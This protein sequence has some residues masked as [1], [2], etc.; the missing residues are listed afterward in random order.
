MSKEIIRT[1]E[2][3]IASEM[4]TLGNVFT[5]VRL[6]SADEV[7]ARTANCEN[8]RLED[9][10]YKV[11][12]RRRPCSNCI[13][14]RAL[15]EKRQFAKIVRAGGGT[16]YVVADY[17]EVD[18]KPCVME[19]IGKFDEDIMIDY[20]DENKSNEPAAEYFEKSYTDVLTGTYNRRYYEEYES[21]ETITGGI[22]MI[23]VDDFK[24]YNDV[25][26]HDMGDEVLKAIANVIKSSVRS[27]D[28]VVRYG[29]DEFLLIVSGVK[30]EAFARCLRDIGEGVR[31]ITFD[32]Y[33]AIKPS[34]STGFVIC[35]G[36][37]VKN[38][39]SR[40]DEFMYLAKKK[41]DFVVTDADDVRETALRKKARVL[42]VDDSAFNREIISSILKNE[43]E[44]IEAENGR[45]ALDKMN[46]YGTDVSAVL[47]DLIMPEMD[48]FE[49]LDNM[50][51]RGALTDIPVI[52]ITGDESNDSKRA[53]YEKG[54]ADYIMRPFDAKVVYR[55][56]TNAVKLY[57]RQKRLISRLTGEIRDKEKNRNMI[58]EILSQIV[59]SADV[60]N[61]TH[62][63]HIMK[64]TE[65]MLRK[66]AA[67]GNYGITDRDVY[68]ISTAAALHDIGKSRIDQSILNKKT[69][70]TPEEVEIMK[71][72]TVWGEKM[73][74]KIEA[75]A[76][77]PLVKYACEICRHHHERYDGKGYPDGL[78]G[79]E[80]PVSAQAVSIC[81]V[82]DALVTERSYKPAYSHEKAMAMIKNGE[83]GKF[84]P[85]LLECLDEC[86]DEFASIIDEGGQDII[87]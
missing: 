9:D 80:I 15:T 85:L 71:T 78:A 5:A 64:F 84:N 26:G 68:V 73:L 55:R 7:G 79:D 13:S 30:K 74:K 69:K 18:G 28:T 37:T 20:A 1:T 42:V 39:V 82:Y 51:A 60:D 83:C 44:I 50:N 16:F 58:V 46:E 32:D 27:G 17:R 86:A 38:A 52:A 33:P 43:Y 3:R 35:S 57:S 65:L 24:I 22:A 14:Y 76:N 34:V 59:E 62:A 87:G 21:K 12:Q 23:D 36:E 2:K 67:K 66:I 61:G 63:G 49:F 48:G 19:M 72:H 10:C 29:G 4:K 41:K 31:N 53:A 45:Q 56:V 6:L 25:F 40:A 70:F 47:L 54:V 75:Y 8:K 11:W 81:D 77:E